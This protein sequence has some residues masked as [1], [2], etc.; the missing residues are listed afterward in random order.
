MNVPINEEQMGGPIDGASRSLGG[1][2][3]AGCCAA[4]GRAG[5]PMAGVQARSG[6]EGLRFAAGPALEFVSMTAGPT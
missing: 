3:A 2:P 4:G 1:A 5:A 6:G